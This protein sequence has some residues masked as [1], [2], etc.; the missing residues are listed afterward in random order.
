MQSMIND[1]RSQLNNRQKHDVQQTKEMT[2]IQGKLVAQIQKLEADL[3]AVTTQGSAT[4]LPGAVKERT[5]PVSVCILLVIAL[6]QYK[7]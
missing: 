6:E 7:Y 5:T 3:Q 1:I 4:N 2:E